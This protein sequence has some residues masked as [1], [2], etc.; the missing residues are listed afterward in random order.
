MDRKWK[1]YRRK[2]GVPQ[3]NLVGF[4]APQFPIEGAEIQARQEPKVKKLNVRELTEKSLLQEYAPACV[5]VD[6]H[7]DILYV[8]G[9]T[10]QYL[11]LPPGEITTNILRSAR[12][13]LRL[14][15]AS[16]LHKVAERGKSIRYNGLQVKANGASQAVNLIVKPAEYPYKEGGLMLV[17]FEEAAPG[18]S[19]AP[20]GPEN[21][22]EEAAPDRDLQIATLERELNAKEEYLQ[23]TIEELE[24]ANEELK[25]TNEELQSTNEELQSTN[26][27]LE[28]SKEELQSINEELVTVNSELQ[29]KIDGL[30]HANNDMNNLLAGTGIGTIFVDSQLNIQRFTPAVTRII[31]LIPT[32]VGRPLGHIV[33]NLI[34]YTNL[35]ED[36]RAVLENLVMRELEVQT[37]SGQWYLMRI[38]PYRTL[39]NA[40]EGAVLTFVEI[41]VL[42]QL[43]ANLRDN[44]DRVRSL[45]E[46]A[47]GMIWSIDASLHLI[48]F[49]AGFSED[50]R[51]QYG[52]EAELGQAMPPDWLPQNV[53]QEWQARYQRALLGETFLE[54]VSL[55][56]APGENHVR[57]YIFKP[58][59]AA[60]RKVT[61]V[62]CQRAGHFPFRRRT[63]WKI[64]R[65]HPKIALPNCAS[66][67]KTGSASSLKRAGSLPQ[68]IFSAWCTSWKCTRSN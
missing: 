3:A 22:I 14:E 54:E 23:T 42:K 60:N 4:N 61:G 50:F 55:P 45:E 9:H 37:K 33:S 26:E 32:D 66:R 67:L 11:E 51:Q 28:T 40:V 2:G 65:A 48:T 64:S 35:E 43:R 17:I 36:T 44:Q 21:P 53:Q 63:A 39:E 59:L 41:S 31:N 57:Q 68:P 18:A 30:S 12:P 58:V 49:N 5:L 6:N 7:G 20:A 56:S 52:R 34:N 13:G 15:L 25:S 29:Q 24:T 1:L 62:S 38:L 27:E 8:Y 10:G 16:A 47:S 19:G 46:A